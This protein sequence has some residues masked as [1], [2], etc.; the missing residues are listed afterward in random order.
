MKELY[1]QQTGD[2]TAHQRRID[3][4]LRRLDPRR[5]RILR[6]RIAGASLGEIGADEGCTYGSIAS[7]IKKSMEAVR[8]A[9]A[10]EPRFNRVGHPG[11]ASPGRHK[12]Q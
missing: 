4:Q 8:K 12:K 9:I 6:R 3:G 10:G 2:K 7:V 11:G 5:Q 1:Q